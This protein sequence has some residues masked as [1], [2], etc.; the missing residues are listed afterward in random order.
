MPGQANTVSVTMA[1]VIRLPT[2][3]PHKV[4]TGIRALRRQC[5]QITTRSLRPLMRASLTNS[6]SITSSIAERVMRMKPA[7]RKVESV[8]T[9]STK[10]SGPPMRPDGSQPSSTLNTKISS[11][12]S[13]KLGTATPSTATV[14]AARS[15]KPPRLSAAVTPSGMPR[16]MPRTSAQ[17]I[18]TSVLGRRS[19]NASTA[20]CLMRIEVP[21][22]P[23]IALPTKIANCSVSGPS[24]PSVLVSAARSSAV[25][26]SGTIRST[27]LPVSRPR[28]KTIVATMQSR[29]TPWIRRRAMKRFMTGLRSL[30]P[31][32][33]L[34]TRDALEHV[35]QL[36][37]AGDRL[38]LSDL[39]GV[40]RVVAHAL[41][42]RN[43][44][45]GVRH[46]L[47]HMV[48]QRR[49][50]FAIELCEKRAIGLH[51]V[52]A[53]L[54]AT[55]LVAQEALRAL[56]R[57][58]AV[59]APWRVGP[60][61]RSVHR[62]PA[63]QRSL[64]A[65]LHR[66]E[67]AP[68]VVLQR[69]LDADLGPHVGDRGADIDHELRAGQSGVRELELEAVGIA[70][71]GEDL[72]R[73]H[74][75]VA[76]GLVRPFLPAFGTE[77]VG[78]AE[79]GEGMGH[80]R[81]AV[82]DVLDHLLAVDRQRQRL[83]HAHLGDRRI[84]HLRLVGAP[85]LEDRLHRAR[86]RQHL[87][88]G[89]RG[90]KHGLGADRRDRCLA[91]A[92]HRQPCALLRH[93]EDREILEVRPA[94]PMRRGHRGELDA[95]ARHVADELPGAAADRLLAELLLADLLDIGLGHDRALRRYRARQGR[96]QADLRA[97]GVHLDRQVVDHLDAL[98]RAPHA[99]RRGG[100]RA[101]PHLA[102][103][104]ELHVVGGELVAVV[105]GLARP[106]V[107]GPGE[108]VRGEFPAFGDTR[109][110]PALLE[111]EA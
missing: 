13:Q 73:Q 31:G 50:L 102:L 72:L 82:H 110:D 96:R 104:A 14:P 57:E 107:E 44:R 64:V 49:A 28:K 5:F 30:L 9:G 51:E 29:I 35:A 94:A 80:A 55:G 76:I 88:P 54:A 100:E 47:D 65:A 10:C 101:R 38:E 12:P 71:L 42:D 84:L 26:S 108:A 33:F 45:P 17:G 27:G 3:T 105:E 91:G 21:R 68:F 8:M 1:P 75:I 67:R 109:A 53:R 58:G 92:H 89:P 63:D 78:I 22:S 62:G 32:L 40:D 60:S 98:D 18:S 34:G 46:Q 19:K 56:R 90:A 52:L 99:R 16:I 87:Q 39:L 106:D 93:Q 66:R 61:G 81:L 69:H 11:T 2:N 7:T 111:V 77:E 24:R 70:L 97:G 4:S 25:A 43:H 83:A 59:V 37:P 23:R 85:E 6:L 36:V 86:H 15:R 103:E 79:G 48:G 95:V 41:E 20:G 74:R